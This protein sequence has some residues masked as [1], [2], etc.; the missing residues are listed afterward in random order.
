MTC[1]RMILSKGRERSLLRRHPWIFS[2][3]VKNVTGSPAAGETVEVVDSQGNFLA[4]AAFS[5]SSQL[6]G[7]VWSFNPSEKIDRAF[8]A[9][10]IR[11]A[12]ALREQLGYLTPGSGCRLLFSESD[13]LPGIIADWYDGFIVLQLV[14]AGAEF[15]RQEII[16]ALSELP[17]TKGIFERSDASV[18]RREGLEPA[19][20]HLAGE[21]VDKIIISENK[22]KF[23]VDPLHGQKTGFYFDLRDAR[24]A[25]RRFVRGKR[26]LNMFSYTG[27]FAVN[28]LDA[29][30]EYVINCDSSRPALE[31]AG[32]NLALNGFDSS[33]YENICGD[34]FE[35]L[36]DMRGSGEKFDVVILDPPKLIDSRNALDRGCRAY[37]FLARN[38]FELLPYG[39]IMFNFSCSGL[40]V[41]E[42]FQKITAS[43]AAEVGCDIRIL[44]FLQQSADHPVDIATPETLY[45]K[46]IISGKNLI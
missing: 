7:R 41:P 6:T 15:H 44:G 38:G 5:P 3:A 16:S 39:G 42:L 30:A 25:L 35:I 46:G 37:Q 9:R 14:S 10:K 29:G 32:R 8:F 4:F 22:L 13:G 23:E 1:A 40:M 31:Q 19:S 2:G 12:A 18:R 11:N 20:G 36:K 34:C 43:A 24:T 17:G 21:S 26:V 27:A 33:K 28:A 45:L